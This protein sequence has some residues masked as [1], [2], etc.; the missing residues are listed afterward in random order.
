MTKKHYRKFPTKVML[1]LKR[2]RTKPIKGSKNVA[3]LSM[4]TMKQQSMK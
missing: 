3:N 1:P 4:S 2:L